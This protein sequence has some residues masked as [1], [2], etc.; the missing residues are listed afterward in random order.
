ML[1]VSTDLNMTYDKAARV[2]LMA[3]AEAACNTALLLMEYNLDLN[4]EQGAMDEAAKLSAEYAQDPASTTK[5]LNDPR[6]SALRPASLIFI[7]QILNEFG[8][9]VADNVT[10]IR[11]LVTNKLLTETAHPDA[12]VRLRA[13]ELLGKISDV[14]LFS[15][16]SEVTIHNKS[17]DDIRSRLRSKLSKL[18]GN[19]WIAEDAVIIE[20]EDVVVDKAFG[21]VNDG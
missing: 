2:E 21:L 13:L 16:K 11:N 17:S 3:R 10:S 14:G 7:D 12:R 15:E 20:S 4:P 18:S 19:E 9:N 6:M 5:A 8:Q 1:D